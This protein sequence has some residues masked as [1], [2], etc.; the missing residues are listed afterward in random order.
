MLWLCGEGS[1]SRA[2]TTEQS[3]AMKDTDLKEKGPG[4]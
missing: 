1:G 4:I 2:L 3:T